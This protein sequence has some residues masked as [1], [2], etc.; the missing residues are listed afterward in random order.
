MNISLPGLVE[1]YLTLKPNHTELVLATIIDTEGSTYRKVGARMLITGEQECYGLLGGDEL[2]KAV[3]AGAEPV[4]NT[5]SIQVLRFDANHN[6]AGNLALELEAGA[7][8]TVLLEYLFS[9]DKYNTMELL[10]RGL[11]LKQVVLATICESSIEDFIPGTNILIPYQETV[12]G[13]PEQNYYLA[14]ADIAVQISQTLP[15][16]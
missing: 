16:G 9:N 6:E 15:K 11:K 2:H 1:D 14:M 12:T 5:R 4:F 7:G 13:T 3:L 10:L 8:I